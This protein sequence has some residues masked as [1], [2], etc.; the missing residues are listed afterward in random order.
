MQR[1]QFLASASLASAI[2]ALPAT[3]RAAAGVRTTG[4][5]AA[6]VR[7]VVGRGDAPFRA[8]L[9]RFFDARR[10]DNPEQATSLGVDTGPRAG[11][12]SKL[13]DTS[14]AG[15]TRQFARAKRELAALKAVPR[16]TLGDAAR[17]DYDVVGDGLQREIAGQRYA[18]GAS[19]GRHAPY[20]PMC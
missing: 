6:G 9:D 15:Q 19:A 16:D 10:D 4:V 14:R 5:R 13:A 2:M 20:A 1:R 8:M 7:N 3:L 11:L 18:F 17:L 12:K